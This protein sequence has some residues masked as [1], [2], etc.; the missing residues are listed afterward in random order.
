MMPNMIKDTPINPKILQTIKGFM[1]FSMPYNI[2][3]T[4]EVS[5]MIVA[6]KEIA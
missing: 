6:I 4:I 3:K 2:Q 1:R 5:E